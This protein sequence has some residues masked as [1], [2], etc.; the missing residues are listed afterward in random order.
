[1][2]LTVEVEDK[3]RLESLAER[4][5]M[6]PSRLAK[7]LLQAGLTNLEQFVSRPEEERFPVSFLSDLLAP[8]ARAKGLTEEDLKESV[9]QSRRKIGAERYSETIES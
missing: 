5:N 7:L 8:I 4:L 2:S 6:S 1:M 3:G 9:R